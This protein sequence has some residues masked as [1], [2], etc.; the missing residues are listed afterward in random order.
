M[1]F[2]VE[3]IP[4]AGGSCGAAVMERGE[5]EKPEEKEKPDNVVERVAFKVYCPPVAPRGGMTGPHS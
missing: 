5:F 2:S 1:C 4:T 3:T